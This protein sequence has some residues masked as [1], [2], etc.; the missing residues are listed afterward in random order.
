MLAVLAVG[1]GIARA[2]LPVLAP[3]QPLAAQTDSA[4]ES[5]TQPDQPELP[6]EALVPLDK[7]TPK[8]GKLKNS[9]DADVK[10]HPQAKKA[11]EEGQEQFEKGNYAR[12][13]LKLEQAAGFHPK[14]PGIQKL[15]GRAYLKQ[16]NYGKAQDHLAKAAELAPDD[17]QLQFDLARLAIAQ[18]QYDRATLALRRALKTS[19]ADDAGTEKGQ[20]LLLLGNLLRR[21]GHYTASLECFRQLSHAIDEDPRAYGEQ[22]ELRP[23]V[24]RPEILLIR[25]ADLLGKLRRYEDAA[26]L[27][28]RAYNLNRANRGTASALVATLARAGK[29]NQAEQALV[30]MAAEPTLAGLVQRLADALCRKAEDPKMPA[31]LVKAFNEAGLD[32]P[33]LTLSLAKTAERLGNRNQAE[34][35][36]RDLLD[37]H[38]GHTQAGAYLAA[39]LAK[40]N[41]PAKALHAL[42]ELLDHQ[43]QADQAV[44]LGAQQVAAGL[45]DGAERDFAKIAIESDSNNQASLLFVAGH[46]AKARGKHQLAIDLFTRATKAKPDF[47][48]A[49]DALLDAYLDAG[50]ADQA[51]RVLKDI[52][53]QFKEGYF[54]AYARGKLALA[55]ADASK[56]A[57]NLADAVEKNP[58]HL[59]SILLLS[60]AYAQRG[61]PGDT[62]LAEATLTDGLAARPDAMQLHR[63][64]FDLHLAQREPRK[65][66]DVVIGLLR[67]NPDNIT[68]QIML[69]E[70]YLATGE[71]S[72]AL[73]LLESLEDKDPDNTRIALL[74]MRIALD[75]HPGLLPKDKFDKLINRLTDLRTNDPDNLDI[76]QRLAELFMREGLHTTSAMAWQKLHTR[77]PGRETYSRA[78]AISLIRAGQS[79][80]AIDVLRGFLRRDPE[81]RWALVLL[82]D[83]LVRAD[84]HKEAA[85]LAKEY[86]AQA[87]DDGD[88]S[89]A[90]AL[91]SYLVDEIYEPGKMYAQAVAAIDQWL[92]N[93]D[94]L[95]AE[96]LLASKIQ[97][98]AKMGK[99][100]DAIDIGTAWAN[101]ADNPDR[102]RRLTILALD[103]AKAYTQ[104]VKLLRKW[105]QELPPATAKDYRELLVIMLS[106]DGQVDQAVKEAQKAIQEN[107]TDRSFRALAVG[108]LFEAKRYDDAL[109]LLQG[110]VKQLENY[111]PP[112]P[113]SQPATQPADDGDVVKPRFQPTAELAKIRAA[114]ALSYCRETIVRLYLL[115]EDPRKAL[116][117][118]E[119]FLKKEPKNIELHQLQSTALSELGRREDGA[120]VLAKAYEIDPDDI[121]LANNL[122]Y[123]YT[124]MGVKLDQAERLIRQALQGAPREIAFRDT[125]AWV[126]YKRGKFAEAGRVFQQ[127]LDE[128]FDADP[129]RLEQLN[130]PV[131][132]DHAGDTLYRLGWKHRAVDLWKEALEHAR[133]QE[134]PLSEITALITS[135]PAKISA[136]QAGKEPKLAPV[137]D[138]PEPDTND[139]LE[140]KPKANPLDD[141]EPAKES[142]ET[143]PADEQ[144][145][146][147]P[148][149]DDD[150]ED[151]Q[152]KP[153][154][155]DPPAD[156]EP[157]D[158]DPF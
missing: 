73:N 135:L 82:M 9:A 65:A 53:E 128:R 49:Y 72:K 42:A 67:G 15:T 18:K 10:L 89:L 5:A 52:D 77:R 55:Q 94:E 96:A 24:D 37:N 41:E 17:F 146:P 54:A 151:K 38:A 92:P 110:W 103:E 40:R 115:K 4:E 108:A 125:L 95:R 32:N 31:R 3:S 105:V 136:A 36:T 133:K 62:A 117:T 155:D 34:A 43:A 144:K 70:M 153:A 158:V 57:V 134:E 143:P 87:D 85:D 157:E 71:K 13:I 6:K 59:P 83:T 99:V 84:K 150:S 98:L 56:A 130:H 102:P 142:D 19:N 79:A 78:L 114:Q 51:Q 46:V 69:A 93:V 16:R 75:D 140:G 122:A 104:A 131:I 118:S 74:R 152:P 112:Q 39:L 11:Y 111:Q 23:L 12:A 81:S 33:T 138:M 106:E 48:A 27:L 35:I 8:I 132:L 101:K 63:R 141:D 58:K 127:M 47:P 2:A 90:S 119:E 116:L 120:H 129:G 154:E 60:E 147:Q 61:E 68:G 148:A 124:D 156:E 1:S 21:D 22:D 29:Y 137:V 7:L 97:L 121:S 80:Q 45:D 109:E 20:A 91:R 88:K 44:R 149:K 126:L 64:L 123:V 139:D 50:R 76:Q 100:T 14:H 66:R 113:E 145:D 107:P 86:I 30:E 26:E 25:Q 28:R